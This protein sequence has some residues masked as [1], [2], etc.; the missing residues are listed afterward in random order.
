MMELTIADVRDSIRHMRAR[1][2]DGQGQLHMAMCRLSLPMSELL[3][4]A[5]AASS[6]RLGGREQRHGSQAG[7]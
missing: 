3:L 4:A 7:A 6:T 5:Y 1:L 2:E